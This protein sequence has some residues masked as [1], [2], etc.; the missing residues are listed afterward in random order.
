MTKDDAALQTAIEK[1]SDV[2]LTLNVYLTRKSANNQ[3]INEALIVLTRE[4]I[5]LEGL[6]GEL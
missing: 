1:L 5:K 3:E 2:E 4:R 6:L